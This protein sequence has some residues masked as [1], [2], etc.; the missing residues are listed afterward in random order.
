MIEASGAADETL[1]ATET[2][3]EWN[4]LERKDM[5]RKVRREN[6]CTYYMQVSMLQARHPRLSIFTLTW[7]RF[8]VMTLLRLFCGL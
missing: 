4:K 7:M 8:Y 6:V 1:A 3:A 5:E 2:L